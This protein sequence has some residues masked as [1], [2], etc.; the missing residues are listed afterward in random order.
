MLL[1]S[2]NH[3]SWN[4]WSKLSFR[5]VCSYFLLYIFLMFFGGFFETPFR[6]IGTNIL[7]ITYE[8]D[9]SGFGSG[10]NTYAYVSLFVNVVLALIIFAAWSFLD[11]KR[12]SY[13]A[14][15]YWFKVLLR[16]FLIFFM[17]TY[18]F[19]KV[20]QIQ[21]QSPSLIR[22]LQPLGEMSPMG[23]AWTYMGYSKGFGAFAGIMEIIGGILLIPRRTIALGAFIII[24][25]MAQV[26]MMNFTFDIPVKLFSI[27]LV[28][29]AIVL[30]VSDSKRFF[31]AFINDKKYAFQTS[32]HPIKEKDYHYI[33]FWIKLVGLI[34]VL[35]FA[36]IFGYNTEKKMGPNNPAN[37][38]EF[39]GIWETEHFIKNGDTLLPLITNNDYWRYLILERKNQSTV[40]T[41]TDNLERYY[42]EVDTLEQKLSMYKPDGDKD[43]LNISYT[44]K[45]KTLHLKGILEEDSIDVYLSL[46]NLEDFPLTSRGFNWINER[47]YNR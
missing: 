17:F 44:Y 29:M 27:H 32:Y 3:S 6:W 14:F 20:F 45:T 24:G 19:V 46:K 35:S 38:S 34:F 8:Y 1:D 43:S 2:S 26:A 33:M 40:K 41:M 21:F 31:Y 13:N 36:V 16:I 30:F 47:P 25:V 12:A 22:L 5:L 4:I 37:L 39:Y 42:F 11:R 23:L 10:D 7:N 28:L 15:Y 18:G 9:R